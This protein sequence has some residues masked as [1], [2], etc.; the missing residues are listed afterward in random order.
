MGFFDGLKDFVAPALSFFGGERKN[1]AQIQVAREQM[2][3]QREMSNT[4][5]R[6]AMEDMK[7]AGLNPILAGKLG[8]ASTPGGAM[9]QLHDSITTAV[10]TGLQAA[11]TESDIAIQDAQIEKIEEEVNNLEVSRKLTEE[12]TR[13][14]SIVINEIE[15]RIKKIASETKGIDLK[16]AQTQIVTKFFKENNP[17]AIA[18]EMGVSSDILKTVVADYYGMSPDQIGDAALGSLP[19]VGKFL[20]GKKPGKKPTSFNRRSRRNTQRNR[21]NR[22]AN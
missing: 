21:R 11:K 7:A 22:Y 19:F 12:Q 9:P 15:E 8:G 4:A 14:V 5:Y 13:Q 2:D 3:F 1:D 6:R 20:K 10:N 18:K 17:A 16:N